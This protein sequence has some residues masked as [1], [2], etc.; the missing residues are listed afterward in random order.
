MNIRIA[1]SEDI[2]VLCQYDRHI[3]QEELKNCISLGRVYIAEDK[4]KFI[5]WLRYN[6]FWDNIPF[7][8]MLYLLDEYRNKGYGKQIVAYWEK[9]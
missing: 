6:L 9:K 8:N 4:G 3:T 7:M 2:E 5:G 1:Q